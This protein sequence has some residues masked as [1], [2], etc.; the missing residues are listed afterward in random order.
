MVRLGA[1]AL[2]HFFFSGSAA[3]TP[4]TGADMAPP[5][6]FLTCGKIK[7]FAGGGGG[8]DGSGWLGL[9]WSARLPSAPHFLFFVVTPL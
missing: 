9:R 5:L 8:E 2:K 4:G 3:C 7:W 1:R 6:V